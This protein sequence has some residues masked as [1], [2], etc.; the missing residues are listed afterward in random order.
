LQETSKLCLRDGFSKVCSSQSIREEH[1]VMGWANP[2]TRNNE[3]IVLHHARACLNADW[4]SRLF[5]SMDV[6]SDIQNEEVVP[7]FD[8]H[9]LL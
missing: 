6:T 3:V 4:N 1:T 8:F 9:R 2:S 7:T 5:M